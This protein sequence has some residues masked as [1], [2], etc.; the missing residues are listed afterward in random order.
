MLFVKYIPC[1]SDPVKIIDAVRLKKID[2]KVIYVVQWYNKH[3]DQNFLF[4]Q[5]Y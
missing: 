4:D 5:T 1:V 2:E 3:F